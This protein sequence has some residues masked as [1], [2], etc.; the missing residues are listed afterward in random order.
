ML[1]QFGRLEAAEWMTASL[2]ERCGRNFARLTG[3]IVP[4]NLRLVRFLCNTLSLR[5]DLGLP[6]SDHRGEH[7]RTF[8]IFMAAG[9]LLLTAGCDSSTNSGR[10]TTTNTAVNTSTSTSYTTY[11]AANT[12]TNTSAS[13]STDT[14]TNCTYP[15]CMASLFASCTPSGTC[16][17][18]TDSATLSSNVCY[19]NGVKEL[20]SL[21]MTTQAAVVTVKNGNTTCFSIEETAS[22]SGTTT[23]LTFKN[24]SGQ[25]IATGTN[26]G[27]TTTITCTGS[28]PVTLDASCD[29]TSGAT[30]DCT[31]GS[32]S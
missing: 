17:E 7:M 20:F 30:T 25:T 32:C 21:D 8:G 23:N 11:T 27:A 31:T 14:S 13:T 24:A 22:S 6:I 26:N 16:V 10:S 4:L 3:S 19:S 12:A 9:V 28:Q 15:S 2:R 18:Q 29:P 1:L 5:Q